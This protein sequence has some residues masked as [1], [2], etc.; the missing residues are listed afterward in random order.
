MTI[1]TPHPNLH[2]NPDDV[3]EKEAPPKAAKMSILETALALVATDVG[4][5]LLGLPYAFYHVGFIN[6]CFILLLMALLCYFSSMMYLHV[7][8]L[9]PERYESIYEISYYLLGRPF[10]FT[11]LIIVLCTTIA[12][13]LLYYIILGETIGHL[14]T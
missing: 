13:M 14:F 9:T 4:G 7:K 3:D 12:S 8:H 2:S 6:G 1:D 11:V 5:A 10:V